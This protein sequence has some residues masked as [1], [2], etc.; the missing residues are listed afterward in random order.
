MVL[1]LDKYE[2]DGDRPAQV[3]PTILF[4]GIDDIQE[5]EKKRVAYITLYDVDPNNIQ[6]IQYRE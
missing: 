4:N 1:L 6:V 2:G 5:A 3:Y